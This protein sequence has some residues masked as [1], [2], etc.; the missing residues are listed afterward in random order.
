MAERSERLL[1]LIAALLATRRPLSRREIRNRVE[2][3]PEG[4]EAFRRA[5]ER[6]KAELRKLDLPLEV[7]EIPGSNPPLEGY[8]IPGDRYRLADPGLEPDELAAINLAL[9]AVRLQGL[10]LSSGLR[11]LGGF[12]GGS[13]PA[14]ELA[15]LTSSPYLPAVFEAIRER[16]RVHFDYHGEPRQVDVFRLQY[17]RGRWYLVGF[18]I[19][20]DE[21]RNYRLDRIDGDFAVDAPGTA[22]TPIPPGGGEGIEVR[23]W[24][25]GEGD[26]VTAH[27]AV[28]PPQ[29]EIAVRVVGAEGV[30]ARHDDGTVV[31]RLEVRNAEALRS[32]VLSMFDD[33]EL[34]S[35]PELRAEL[36]DWLRTLAGAP[37]ARSAAQEGS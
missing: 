4:D 8:R 37:V 7:S 24:Q 25:T 33:A 5:F 9:G 30:V 17:R 19:D 3:Y 10:D 20:K 1:K 22:T 12:A 13:T 23:G 11:K 34:L 27:V 14:D 15:T 18:D 32:F 2:G 36:V 31:L 21:S 6:D 16:A 26:A 28:R 35:P 29:A